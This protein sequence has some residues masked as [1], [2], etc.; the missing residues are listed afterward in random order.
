MG[1][2]FKDILKP[3]AEDALPYSSGGH[4]DTEEDY[5]KRKLKGIQKRE[6][7]RK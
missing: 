4:Y 3:E 6:E 5:M 1:R 2:N 7:L